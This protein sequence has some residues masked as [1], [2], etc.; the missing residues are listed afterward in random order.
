[1]K[2]YGESRNV[3]K[4]GF[5]LQH[6][7]LGL[8]LVL[9]DSWRGYAYWDEIELWEVEKVEMAACVVGRVRDCVCWILTKDIVA[10][11]GIELWMSPCSFVC[12]VFRE[13]MRYLH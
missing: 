2:K 9:Q 7:I 13:S 6:G 12:L 4:E 3:F 11:V 1:M 5:Y 8:L 10:V